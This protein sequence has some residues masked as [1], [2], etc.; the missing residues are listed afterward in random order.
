MISL[1][2]QFGRSVEDRT[3]LES[4]FDF[5]LVWDR[6]ET[7]DSARPSLLATRQEQLGLRLTATSGKIPTI[8]VD[9]IERPTGIDEGLF[10]VQALY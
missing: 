9:H 8:V 7:G 1:R 2:R 10:S 5:E 3:Q 4:E 6:D